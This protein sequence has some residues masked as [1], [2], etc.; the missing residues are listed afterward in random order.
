MGSNASAAAVRHDTGEDH[1]FA[2][3]AARAGLEP[4]LGRRYAADPVSVLSEFGLSAAEAPYGD[5][6]APSAVLVDFGP[7][8]SEP[9]YMDGPVTVEDLDGV[10]AYGS[11]V[12][13]CLTCW[14]TESSSLHAQ[15]R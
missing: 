3:L 1:R 13:A 6:P 7:F 8:A 9:V 11:M 10:D 15:G 4:E 5:V 2:E 14:R 12:R